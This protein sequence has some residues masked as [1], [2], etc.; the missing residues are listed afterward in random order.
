MRIEITPVQIHEESSRKEIIIK[1][2]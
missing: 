2:F 1:K